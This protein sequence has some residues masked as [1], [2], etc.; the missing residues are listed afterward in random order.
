[1]DTSSALLM[2]TYCIQA[3]GILGI[4]LSTEMDTSSALLMGTCCIQALGI[5]AIALSL[6]LRWT[7]IVPC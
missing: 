3:L 2:G 4:A 6:L 5:L 7:L 1:M